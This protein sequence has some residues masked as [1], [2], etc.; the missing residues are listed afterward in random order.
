[1][2][3]ENPNPDHLPLK[4]PD[5]RD[6]LQTLEE[7]R[8]HEQARF[9][10]LLR[11]SALLSSTLNL[12]RLLDTILQAVL[13]LTDTEA[14]SILLIDRPSGSL[15]FEA[16]SNFPSGQTERIEVPLEGS[17]AGWVIQHG[18]PRVLQRVK[19]EQEFTVSA[20][21]DSQTDFSTDS[22]LAVPLTVK[23]QVIGVLEALNKCGG[24]S[25]DD[26]DQETLTAMAG[27]AAIAIENARLF[28]QNDLV[29]EMVHELRTPLMALTTMSE[30]LTRP[31]LPSGRARE[32]TLT[33][34]GETQRLTNMVS[35]FLDF[36]RLESGRVKLKM[37][38]VHLE[39]VIEET[40][41]IQQPAARE[42][43]ITIEVRP[44]PDLPLVYGDA[45]QLKQ[46]LL[47][48]V[49]NAIKYN[50]PDGSIVITA[51]QQDDQVKVCV[52]D[53]GQGI[54]ADA[55]KRLFQRFYRV[56]DTEGYSSGT[57]LGLS[58]ARQIVHE[59]GGRIW[60][61]SE[62]QQGSR[63]CFVIPLE[64]GKPPSDLG[65]DEDFEGAAPAGVF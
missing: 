9:Q 21:I 44:D 22:L 4:D 56:P 19:E 12:P 40:V 1:M 3:T 11:I 64:G 53:T 37:G 36:A 5:P 39:R 35:D 45:D 20:Q 32:L 10:S 65:L 24:R 26:E 28:Q 58:I 30:L 51:E 47:N 7:I 13:R 42:R 54:P 49:S 59:H 8:R 33:L 27:P 50:R 29:A 17:V 48:L 31:D 18:R 23:G 43:G 60:A 62:W 25:F 55:M 34:Q 46:V 61:Q 15:Y 41:R 63:F 57:G 16:T 14:S 2:T 52:Q 6:A 38:A